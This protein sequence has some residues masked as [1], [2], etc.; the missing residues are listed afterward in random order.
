MKIREAFL[1]IGLVALAGCDSD[2]DMLV[3]VVV[4]AEIPSIPAGVIRVSLWVYDPMLADAP[5][6]LADMDT[7]RFRHQTGRTDTFHLLL[8][9][10][11]PGSQ[12]YYIT[13]RGFELTPSCEVYVL[14]GP[15]EFGAPS[16]IVLQPLALRTC[17]GD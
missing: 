2:V 16:T 10:D 13:A 17:A 11:V 9:A 1:A 4:P 15:S 5:A 6:G 12:R 8:E 3:R 7:V 14:Y